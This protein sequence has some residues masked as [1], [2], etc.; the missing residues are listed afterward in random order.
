[1]TRQRCT[2]LQGYQAD[3]RPRWIEM[4]LQSVREW[5]GVYG[6]D[7]VFTDRFFDPVPDWFRAKC[8]AQIGPLT[9]LARTLWM[10]RCLDAGCDAVVWVDADVLVFAPGR[11]RLPPITRLTAIREL[12]PL[13]SARGEIRVTGEGVNG[14][15]LGAPADGSGL[16]D[17]RS[18]ITA[19]IRNAAPG[20]IARTM[21][22]PALLTDIGKK[23]GL[24]VLDHIG[25]VTP[26]MAG[27]LLR[28]QPQLPRAYMTA[29]GSPIYAA[30][31]C[32]FARSEGDAAIR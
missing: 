12:T 23:L 4:C 31:L 25:L 26:G 29:F 32:H 5:A 18:A 28:G 7:Y 20:A 2:V 15:I 6:H 19:C 11:L 16:A 13:V 9:D 30:N 10:Q 22:G 21:A 3:A 24:D 14:A 17:Y 1:M 27:A 8:G